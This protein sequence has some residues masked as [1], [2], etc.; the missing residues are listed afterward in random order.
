M[1]TQM[2]MIMLLCWRMYP[3]ESKEDERVKKCNDKFEEIVDECEG[4]DILI[5]YI[6]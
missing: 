3:A 6:L 5:L 2:M 1:L 4:V